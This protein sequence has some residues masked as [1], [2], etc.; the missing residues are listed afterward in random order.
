S[1]PPAFAYARLLIEMHRFIGE[2]KGDSPEAETLADQMDA[3]WYAMTAQEQARMRGLAADLHALRDGGPK[4]ADMAP[5]E[6]AD[7]KRRA[8]EAYNL[9]EAG[10]AD[11]FLNFLR[12]PVPSQLP[13]QFTPFLQ[14]RCWEKLG[15]FETALVFMKEADRLDPDQALSVLL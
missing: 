3:P 12:R 15:D 14:A 1:P 2:G 4:R 10:D 8:R 7:W 13:R 11:A 5:E 6:L 9:G